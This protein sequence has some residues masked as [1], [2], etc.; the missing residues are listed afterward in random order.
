MSFLVRALPTR[1]LAFARTT[2]RVVPFAMAARSLQTAAQA[3]AGDKIP[4]IPVK[5]DAMDKRVDFSSLPGKNIIV[6]VP[7][8]FT[9]TC[10]SQVPGFIA[11]VDKFKAKGV[12]GIYVVSVNDLFV[13]NAWKKAMHAPESMKFVAD[14]QCEL[15]HALG[16]VLDV[17][18]GLG[19]LRCKRTVIVIQ[20]GKIVDIVV[21][22]DSSKSIDTTA[23]NIL[24]KL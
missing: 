16:T 20:D 11:D 6:T 18:A 17:T 19:G 22:G 5:V 3:K 14:D 23:D 7:G 24:A 15:T 1:T 21:E 12:D 10:S 9:P 13:V 4:S 2:P 8:A